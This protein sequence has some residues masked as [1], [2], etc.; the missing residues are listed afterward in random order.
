MSIWC[1]E[2]G[3]AAVGA[4]VVAVSGGVAVLGYGLLLGGSSD[5][6]PTEGDDPRMTAVQEPEPGHSRLCRLASKAQWD[7]DH[8]GTRSTSGTADAESSRRGEKADGREDGDEDPRAGHG[9][10]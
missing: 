5:A 6:A 10:D 7:I 9:E 1:P 3:W 8:H 4:R 2:R